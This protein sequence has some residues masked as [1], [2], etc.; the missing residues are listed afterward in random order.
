MSGYPSALGGVAIAMALALTSPV[1]ASLTLLDNFEALTPGNISG[2]GGWVASG[3]S[4]QVTADPA[5]TPSQVFAMTTDSAK[6][7][8]PLLIANG[9]VRML[10]VRFRIAGQ[11]N[12][13]FG[14]SGSA[15]PDQFGDFETEVGM[16][17]ANNDLRINDDGFYDV[18]ALLQPDRW[19]NLWLWIDNQADTTRLFLND[20]AGA[21]AD[22]ADML[23][24]G[25]QI[26]FVFRTGS[27]GNL[28]TFFIKT[29]G[30]SS[31]NSGPLYLDDIYLENT[32]ALNLLNPTVPLSPGDFNGDRRVDTQD[33]NPFIALLTG[34][35]EVGPAIIPE[36]GGGWLALAGATAALSRRRRT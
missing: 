4:G 20:V 2:Q 19:Y 16:S 22:A 3:D 36:P 25:D 35:G 23:S 26:D 31:I 7:Y 32:G 24:V 11:Q 14:T 13:S 5:G 18:L 12:F 27:A 6:A 17:N 21:D 8:R 10:F 29:G 1:R 9:T 30:G 34:A 33:I 15:Y 28:Q